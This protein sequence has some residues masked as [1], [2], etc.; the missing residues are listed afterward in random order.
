LAIADHCSSHCC[1]AAGHCCALA[2][3]PCAWDVGSH[4][5]TCR[6]RLCDVECSS[7]ECMGTNECTLCMTIACWPC[8]HMLTMHGWLLLASL[9]STP[10]PPY[11]CACACQC[12][13]GVRG[14]IARTCRARL[15]D[16]ECS[17]HRHR[18][19]SGVATIAEYPQSNLRREGL[20]RGCHTV[21]AHH[22]RSS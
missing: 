16:V 2:T 22:V 5:C 4:C 9:P 12:T 15:C 17:S 20:R 3:A 6:A 13:V 11:G 18:S 10:W 14:R 21:R 8:H 7:H 1:P 19:I